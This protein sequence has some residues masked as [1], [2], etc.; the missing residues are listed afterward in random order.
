MRRRFLFLAAGAFLWA[1]LVAH[2]QTEGVQKNVEKTLEQ[3]RLDQ[4]IADALKFN[5]DLRVAESKVRE[6]EAELNRTRM[7]VVSD[8]TYLHAEIQ[9]AQ[10]MVD[11]AKKQYERST[12][13]RKS[14]A[15]SEEDYRQAV[16]ALEKAKSELATKRARLPYLVGKQLTAETL[17]EALSRSLLSDAQAS[18]PA[19]TDEEWLRRAMLDL[20]G[21]PPSGDEMKK[22]LG[23][24]EKDRREKW[25]EQT[26]KQEKHPNAHAD[27]MAWLGASTQ[28]TH[29]HQGTT[30]KHPHGRVHWAE[31]I[32]KETPLTEKLRTVLDK[33]SRFE[34]GDT[35]PKVI[36]DNL[37]DSTLAGLNLS[38]RVKTW[39]KDKIDVKLPQPVPMGAVLQYLEDE[40][41]VM[42]ILREYG[43]VVVAAEEKLP[44][45]AVRVVDFWKR[46]KTTEK[47]EDVESKKISN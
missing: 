16:L 21:R 14:G 2:A 18:K 37:R 3:M 39:K 41:D 43:I 10:A 38:V 12:Q 35:A 36:F 34:Y 45:G 33:T 31:W 27:L 11:Y 1:A 24:P 8:V 19:A 47:K 5:P 40:L 25:L 30:F 4:L 29:C 42:F 44:P 32:T 6:A 28:C 46:G 17:L 15:L 20:I 22:F 23:L 26:L 9:A 7:K 13:L